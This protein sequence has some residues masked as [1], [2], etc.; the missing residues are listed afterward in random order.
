MS[1]PLLI[2]LD[3]TVKI[4]GVGLVDNITKG[5]DNF[6][7]GLSDVVCGELGIFELSVDC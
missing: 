4:S 2:F 1:L 6:H 5:N 7:I 3:A